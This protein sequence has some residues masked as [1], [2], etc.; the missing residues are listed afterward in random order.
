MLAEVWFNRRDEATADFQQYYG[1]NLWDMGL[2][3]DD[4]TQDVLRAAVL[5]SQLPDQ[6]RVVVF[7][8][9]DAAWSVE[10]QLL[11]LIDFTTRSIVYALSD[12]KGEKP[13]PIE[14]PSERAA[15]DEMIDESIRAQDEIDEILSSIFPK[16]SDQ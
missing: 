5:V 9:E 6:A 16:A 11:R 10:A 15:R 1:L 8:H 13:A 7:D 12:G 14:L 2:D 3:G 4:T